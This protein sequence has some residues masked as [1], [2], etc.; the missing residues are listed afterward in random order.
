M[1]FAHHGNC[2]D[3]TLEHLANLPVFALKI[4]FGASQQKRI[5]F[6]FQF[7]LQDLNGCSKVFIRKRRNDS[8]HSARSLCRKRARSGMRNPAEMVDGELYP[9]AHARRHNLRRV[10][11]TRD[12]CL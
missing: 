6:F 4:V 8:A 7:V 5:A 10:D 12:G 9:L 2:I 3:T 1:P 11:E